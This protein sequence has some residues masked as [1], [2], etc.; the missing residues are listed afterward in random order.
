M[1]KN[2]PFCEVFYSETSTIIK[3]IRNIRKQF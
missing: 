3:Q 1:W 2:N